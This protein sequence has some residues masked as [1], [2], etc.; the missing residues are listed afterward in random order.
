MVLGYILTGVGIGG[1]IPA[2]IY[3]SNLSFSNGRALLLVLFL[4]CC[5]LTAAGLLCIIFS[6][7]KKRNQ[8]ALYRITHTGKDGMPLDVCPKCGI[9]IT[10]NT[11]ICPKCGTKIKNGKEME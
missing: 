6:V 1:M 8:D 2:A 3:L 11:Q 10:K 9:N 7:I 4:A 5:V